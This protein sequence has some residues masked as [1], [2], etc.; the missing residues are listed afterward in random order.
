MKFVCHVPCIRSSFTANSTEPSPEQHTT[1]CLSIPCKCYASPEWAYHNLFPTNIEVV[2]CTYSLQRLRHVVLDG[3]FTV[4][5]F[6]YLNTRSCL[7][8]KTMVQ[9][10]VHVCALV[11]PWKHAIT[12]VSTAAL[13]CYAPR[14]GE[15]SACCTPSWPALHRAKQ[16]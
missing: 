15:G 6:V 1:V 14:S 16:L 9:S 7:Q 13:P 4:Y 11:S 10:R 2:P 8:L 12:R 3:H 5:P